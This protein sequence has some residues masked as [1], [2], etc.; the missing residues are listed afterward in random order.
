MKDVEGLK[1]E[2]PLFLQP[3]ATYNPRA[4]LNKS[5]RKWSFVHD[6]FFSRT[7]G[8]CMVIT[9]GVVSES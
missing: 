5:H 7:H 1:E 3:Q 6:S 4:F 8:L 2:I 9:E